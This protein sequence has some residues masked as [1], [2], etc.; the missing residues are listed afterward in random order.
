MTQP[1][2]PSQ[3]RR[4][5]HDGWVDDDDVEA[6]FLP[7]ERTPE[8]NLFGSLQRPDKGRKW[9]HARSG[10]PII[11]QFD[12]S[13]SSWIPFV[14]SSMY[15]PAPNEEGKIVDPE[16]L[17]ELAPGYEKPWRGD[18]EGDDA[19][20]GLGLLHRKGVRRRV[21][22]KRVQVRTDPRFLCL[23]SICFSSPG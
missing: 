21:W 6:S 17:K 13:R 7:T 23:L 3:D 16:F 10:A 9:D 4:V 20:N 22:Y 19:E 18:L 1:A 12:N 14:K 11:L 5:S 15:G 8:R 2:T